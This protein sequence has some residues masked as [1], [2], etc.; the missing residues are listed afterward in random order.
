MKVLK[1]ISV[2]FIIVLVIAQFFGPDTNNG[3]LES[4][5]PFLAETNP[6]AEVKEILYTC[7]FDCHSNHTEYPWYSKITP[8]NYWINSHVNEGKDELNFSKWD[9]YGTQKKNHKFEEMIDLIETK[10]MPLS[11]Y[12]WVH[13]EANLSH[14]KIR[15]V[16]NWAQQVQFKY[17][18]SPKPQ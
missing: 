3:S 4:V 5:E 10:E 17:S 2:I 6:P 14:D 11:S 8:I 7:C 1:K 18:L 9:D 15:E 12:T 13:R 16:I